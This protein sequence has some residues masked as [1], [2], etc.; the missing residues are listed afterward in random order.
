LF[1]SDKCQ[2]ASAY[3]LAKFMSRQDTRLLILPDFFAQLC[4]YVRAECTGDKVGDNMSNIK[5]LGTLKCIACIY[6][7][8]KREELLKYTSETLKTMLEHD[9]LA[10]NPL[11]TIRKFNVKIIQRVGIT[12]FRVKIAKWRY[13]R[14]SRSLIS[15]INKANPV[16]GLTPVEQAKLDMAAAAAAAN[17]TRGSEQLKNEQEE[18]EKIPFEIE[19]ILEQ[20]LT[21]LK[22]KDTI[23]RWSAAKGIGRI[24][25]R[26]SEDMAEDVFAN[27]IEMFTFVE[28]DSAWHG[29][30]NSI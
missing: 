17:K 4:G 30:N 23:V 3:L 9:V 29:K 16:I 21:A 28:D 15:N 20:V 24:T 22:D 12:F 14:G 19:D 18:E 26:L 6:K 11:A 27:L 7:Y 10:N 1:A 25:N 5:L 2:D 13:Q 8:V